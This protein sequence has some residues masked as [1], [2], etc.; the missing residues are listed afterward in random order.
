MET[1][2]DP[3]ENNPSGGK[4]KGFGPFLLVFGGLLLA[5]VLIKLL[6]NLIS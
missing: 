4:L 2:H 5:L 3:A 1:N 6:I